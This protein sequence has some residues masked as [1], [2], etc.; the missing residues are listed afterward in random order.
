MDGDGRFEL[1]VTNYQNEH[2]AL[3]LNLGDRAF[4]EAGLAR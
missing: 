1:F 3:Y 4:L 2:N